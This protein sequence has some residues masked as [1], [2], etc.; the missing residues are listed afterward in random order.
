MSSEAKTQSQDSF[1]ILN[2]LLSTGPILDRAYSDSSLDRQQ[3]FAV[4]LID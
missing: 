2:L 1:M 4:A 3:S